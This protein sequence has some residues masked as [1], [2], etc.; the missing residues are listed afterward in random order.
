MF[1]WNIILTAF[2]IDVQLIEKLLFKQLYFLLMAWG[3]AL[4]AVT[5]CASLSYINWLLLDG[6]IKKSC[7]QLISL[8]CR[9]LHLDGLGIGLEDAVIGEN[10]DFESKLIMS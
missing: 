4:I 8:T 1:Y 9:W 2:E 6:L 7:V 3:N 5:I 10:L